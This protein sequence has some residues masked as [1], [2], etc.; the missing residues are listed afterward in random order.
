MTKRALII[1]GTKGIGRALSKRLADAGWEVAA[2]GTQNLDLSQ[3]TTWHGLEGTYDFVCFCAG[4]I[5]PFPWDRKTWDDHVRSYAIHAMGPVLLLAE[6]R[7]HF[8]WWTKVCF[9]SSVGAINDGIVDLAYGMAKAA[10]DKAARALA[11]HEA[12]GVTL[13]RFD[14]VSTDTLY[15]LPT[16][17]L[18]GRSVLSPEEAASQIIMECEL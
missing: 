1:G 9:V 6:N 8:P 10:L 5:D 12:W 14:L 18:H 11:E 16:E 7:D 13:V 17:T 3:P 15:R 2:Y 4:W